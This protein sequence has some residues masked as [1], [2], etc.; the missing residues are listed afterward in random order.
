[1]IVKLIQNK[2]MTNKFLL[3]MEGGPINAMAQGA[4]GILLTMSQQIA[5]PAM[6]LRLFHISWLVAIYKPKDLQDVMFVS[7][8]AHYVS[9]GFSLQRSGAHHGIHYACL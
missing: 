2:Q 4:T 3:L 5:S 1:M 9:S 6:K 7:H 8:H